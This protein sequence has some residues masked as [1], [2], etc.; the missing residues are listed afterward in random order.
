MS[1]KLESATQRLLGLLKGAPEGAAASPEVKRQLAVIKAEIKSKGALP[2]E[3]MDAAEKLLAAM[4]GEKSASWASTPKKAQRSAPKKP[5][6]KNSNDQ[7]ILEMASSLIAQHD[8]EEDSPEEQEHRRRLAE[9]LARLSAQ[10]QAME[11]T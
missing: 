7:A 10:L 3:L 5:A 11:Q 2:P 9:A 4:E 1:T 8:D 6:K